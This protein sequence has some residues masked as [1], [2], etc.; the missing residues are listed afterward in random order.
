MASTSTH[1][2]GVGGD[3]VEPGEDGGVGPEV[4]AVPPGLNEGVLHGLVDVAVVVEEAGD[5]RANPVFVAVDEREEVVE[6][7]GGLPV[8]VWL[9]RIV[10][11]VG[12]IEGDMQLMGMVRHGT[13][14]GTRRRL[15]D[16]CDGELDEGSEARVRRHLA[17]C[18]RCRRMLDRL[19]ATIADVAVLS[20]RPVPG[21]ESLRDQIAERLGA[22]DTPDARADLD[23]DGGSP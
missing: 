19:Q 13:C 21:G 16:L 14:V 3:A 15:D 5:D 17:G 18:G 9:G 23:D 11:G 8:F 2:G 10:H 1:E 7:G 12:C 4:A 20:N 22:L 6:F